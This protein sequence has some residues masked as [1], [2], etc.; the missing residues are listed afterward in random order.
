MKNLIFDIDGT[1]WNTT[2]V[3]AGAWNR[4]VQEGNVPELASL[5]IT[6]DML[7][8]ELGKPMDVIA[9]DL[10]GDIDAGVKAELLSLCCKYEHEAISECTDDLRYEG[11]TETLAELSK[12]HNLYI[13]SNCQDGYI[14]LV[15]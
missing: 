12:D 11:M 3:V 9:D 7:K 14:E 15:I 10:F 1:L 8:K 4:A 5:H 13:V 2:G 6:A